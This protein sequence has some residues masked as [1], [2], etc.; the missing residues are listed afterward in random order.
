MG[1]QKKL[2]DLDHLGSILDTREWGM[3]HQQQHPGLTGWER[4]PGGRLYLL[5]LQMILEKHLA[6]QKPMPSE[7]SKTV[8][9]H[10]W[11]LV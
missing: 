4:V 11:E 6:K 7:F 5:Q 8:D 3:V 10:F 1:N 2:G 9:K